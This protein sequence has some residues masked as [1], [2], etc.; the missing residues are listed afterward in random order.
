VG[1][2]TN[3]YQIRKPDSRFTS[4]IDRRIAANFDWIMLGMVILLIT[5]G[6]AN[7]Y[8]ATRVPGQGK[9]F[10]TQLRWSIIG[11]IFLATAFVIHY[12]LYQGIG[13]WAYFILNLLLV[14]VLFFGVTRHGASRWLNMIGFSFQPSELAKLGL[15]MAMAKY[16][17]ANKVPHGYTLR[18]LVIPAGIILLP[19]VLIMAQPDLGTALLMML[20]GG[21]MIVFAGMRKSAIIAL[22]IGGILMAP[23]SWFVLLKPYQRERLMTLVDPAKDPLTSGYHINQSLIAIGSGK[24][25][26]KG[27][28]NGTQNKLRFLPEHHT[29]FVF[30]V[31]AEEWGF[32]GCFVLLTLFFGLVVWSIT[33]ALNSKDRFAAFMGV[34][35][36]AIIFWHVVINIGMVVGLAPVVGMPLPFFSYGRS[37]LITMMLAVGL[38]LNISSRRYVF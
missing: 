38:L 5:I 35:L 26:G 32:L 11:M 37:S 7:L 27:F 25:T 16:L 30:S 17:A 12:R 10:A 24:W 34:G 1:W 36:A 9:Y 29:D 19:M 14:M 3:K 33:I 4:R 22:V 28:L 31:Y 21:T 2:R 23:I 13:Y 15:V 8:S 6:L 18:E 20:I